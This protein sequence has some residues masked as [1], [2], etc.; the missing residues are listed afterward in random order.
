M[1]DMGY[2]MHQKLSNIKGRCDDYLNVKPDNFGE[3]ST[4]WNNKD[5]DP[6]KYRVEK[7]EEVRFSS[8]EEGIEI[9]GFFLPGEKDAP[10]VIVV[11]GLGSCKHKTTTLVPGAML[12]KAGFN[13]LLIDV[14]DAGESTFEDGLSAIG[15]EEY[16]DAL[17]AFDWLQS[18][19]NIPADKIGIMGN[20][21]GAATSLIAFSQEPK[22]AA[23]FVDAPF[24]NLT[25]ITSEELKREGYP[26]FLFYAGW[27]AGLLQ[28][29]NLLAYNPNEAITNAGERPLFVIH[30]TGDT[31]IGVHHSYQLRDKAKELGVNAEFWIVE[32]IEHVQDCRCI[33]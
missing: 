23:A 1:W 26:Q 17:G 3:N 19:K 31:R 21:M 28:G 25:Q 22:L 4:F 32:D 10:G 20:S 15:N 6:S 18:E 13:V 11:H 5:F 30:S 24:D 12:N 8:R 2:V 9:A 7:Y 33:S 14:R 29:D 27:V 16:L